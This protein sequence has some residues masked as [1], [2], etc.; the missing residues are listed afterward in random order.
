MARNNKEGGAA[1]K[2][3]EMTVEA[4]VAKLESEVEDINLTGA[5]QAKDLTTF[6]AR[7]EQLKEQIEDI[8]EGASA[9]DLARVEGALSGL[10]GRLQ[11]AET[12]LVS[13][14]AEMESVRE[15]I[16]KASQREAEITE[17]V[18]TLGTSLAQQIDTFGAAVDER[19]SEI[20]TSLENRV[21]AVEAS[22]EER[23]GTLEAS[24]QERLDAVKEEAAK[25]DSIVS[26][27]DFEA[28]K[29]EHE[30]KLAELASSHN[31]SLQTMR[32]QLDAVDDA[33]R[34]DLNNVK[35]EQK[36]LKGLSAETV[37]QLRSDFNTLK[38]SLEG[39]DDI[40][41]KAKAALVELE[42]L[43]AG[44]D[45]AEAKFKAMT[46][47]TENAGNK[48]DAALAKAEEAGSKAEEAAVKI[49]AQLDSVQ[50]ALRLVEQLDDRVRSV[51]QNVGQ[52]PQAVSK[53]IIEQAEE[54]PEEAIS[55]DLGYDLGDILQV[56]V[57]HGASDLH[58]KA[59]T[60]P[61]VRLHGDLVPVGNQ[62]LSPEDARGLIMS[63]M[64]KNQ[65][66]LLNAGKEVDFAYACDGARFRVN[67]FL[68]RGNV[69]AAFRM[70]RTDIPPI[71]SLGLPPVVKKLASLHNGLILVTGPAGSGKS[72]T[73]A[74]VID[75]INTTRKAHVV[76][77]EDPIEFFH[78][79]KMS[80]ITQREV[81]ADTSTFA[82]ALRMSLRQD[83]N[84]IMVGEMRDPETIMMAVTAA[85]TGHL[86]LSTLHTPNA[87]QAVDRILDTFTGDMQR[88]F[89][90]LLANSLR[91]VM[92]QK[93][94]TRA[95]GKGRALAAEV[96]IVTPTISSLIL[97]GKTEDIY[98]YIKEG[99]NDGMQTF[100]QSLLQL[101]NDGVI[102][103][104]EGLFYA[105]Q[106]TEFRMGVEGATTS[107]SGDM[108][109]ETLM[110]WL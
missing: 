73:L 77:V 99:S 85:E 88:Q 30:A 58:L 86:V 36:E 75:Y 89:R 25:S 109:D 7:L 48:A 82:E 105:D 6:R 38:E 90:L 34:A 97:E 33:L 78:K 55:E 43:K 83:P 100:T 29:A 13:R 8:S 68:E 1:D 103:K 41:A 67:A 62:I 61:T 52:A 108:V 56:V 28:A 94:V 95:E 21:G 3:R 22:V 17:K 32:T 50:M 57:K 59:G 9:D 98:P 106:P 64:T 2:G 71:D 93:L 96:M 44:L 27:E 24:L 10:E 80:L 26:K 63:A 39:A 18:E 46:E 74:A 45:E 104:E 72:T 14:S 92:S 79:D 60:P 110:N 47:S 101:Y 23:V 91:G 16:A 40:A 37:E 12:S 87:T 11:D 70:L 76:T 4:R 5:V 66:A 53:P 20:S 69:S 84:V 49:N 102:T 51:N 31:D 65:R 15:E 81:G 42:K 35:N 107:T 54:A 19:V